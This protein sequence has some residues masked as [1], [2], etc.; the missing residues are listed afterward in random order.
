DR[1]PLSELA[2]GSFNVVGEEVARVH[3]GCS[4]PL[5]MIQP[6][7]SVAI[8]ISAG[9]LCAAGGAVLYLS[10]PSV[11]RAFRRAVRSAA[12]CQ[13][14]VIE[15]LDLY[16][17]AAAILPDLGEPTSMDF[18]S[19]DQSGDQYLFVNDV[20]A[21]DLEVR[22]GRIASFFLIGRSPT[23]SP[24]VAGVRFGASINSVTADWA[25][26]VDYIAA[27]TSRYV[28]S[29]AQ[30]ERGKFDC[31]GVSGFGFLPGRDHF[32]QQL[33]TLSE[34]RGGAIKGSVAEFLR[35]VDGVPALPE[36]TTNQRD[37]ISRFRQSAAVNAAGRTTHS[38]RVHPCD[39]LG[40][41]LLARVL[42]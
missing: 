30:K 39:Q 37:V 2:S 27:D 28:E 41:G 36:L 3:F 11:Q 16:A 9:V 24:T 35:T 25:D 6:G 10:V 38:E 18:S 26:G 12:S 1:R 31:Y 21:L 23:F 29:P 40:R 8:A 15:R 42:E 13:A 22:Q 4:I 14:D 7:K 34:I 17:D 20:Y 32:V 33:G 5:L 19:S